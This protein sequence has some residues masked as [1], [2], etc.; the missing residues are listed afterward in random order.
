M[1]LHFRLCTFQV[2][3][4]HPASKFLFPVHKPMQNRYTNLNSDK[5]GIGIC[6]LHFLP[7]YPHC[8]RHFQRIVDLNIQLRL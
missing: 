8:I 7:C 6:F 5:A 4:T 2:R 3:S 1:G